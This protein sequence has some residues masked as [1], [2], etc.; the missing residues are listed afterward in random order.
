M[1]NFQYSKMQ[2]YGFV[3]W[4]FTLVLCLPNAVYA[5]FEGVLELMPRTCQK[6]GKCVLKNALRFTDKQGTVWEAGAGLETDGASIPP[7]FQPFVGKPFEKAFIKAAIIHDHYCGRRVRPWR[8]THRAFYEGLLEQGVPNA[9]ASAMYYAVF[10]AGPKWGDVVPG[11]ACAPAHFQC[12]RSLAV[13]PPTALTQH[14]YV[15]SADYAR[16]LSIQAEMKR[17]I[18]AIERNPQAMSLHKLEELAN[19]HSEL[20]RSEIVPKESIR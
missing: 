15:R 18:S 1:K 5:Q 17:L 8:Q 14:R 9:K 2:N 16:F 19:S 13:A 6:R 3:F 20:A 12:T 4:L 7:L 11:H 10:L